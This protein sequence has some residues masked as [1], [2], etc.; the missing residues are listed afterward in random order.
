MEP[1]PSPDP[2]LLTEEVDRLFDDALEAIVGGLDGR[3]PTLR[4]L[5]TLPAGLRSSIGSFVSLYVDDE[6]NGCIGTV[7]RVEPLGRAVPRLAWSAAFG[8]PRLP[9]CCGRPGST[10]SPS[11]SP[12]CPRSHR[13]VPTRRDADR[14]RTASMRRCGR[15]GRRAAGIVPAERVGAA[16]RPRRLRRPALPQGGSDARILAGRDAG[17]PLHDHDLPAGPEPPAGRPGRDQSFPMISSAC[18]AVFGRL[19]TCWM[20]PSSSMR[21]VVRCSPVNVFP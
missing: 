8:D 15:P 4:P 6:L 7:E 3:P 21:N 14:A 11:R 13:S 20:T 2:V 5:S 18:A 12:C 19:K 16:T 10:G 9:R 17:P 1:L